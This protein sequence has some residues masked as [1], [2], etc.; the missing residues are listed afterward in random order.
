MND[1]SGYDNRN[2]NERYYDNREDMYYRDDEYRDYRNYRD[3]YR[4]RDYDRRGGRINNRDYR[5][6]RNSRNY[7][8]DYYEDLEM[9]IEDMKETSRMLEDIAEMASNMNEKN[10]INK[11]AQKEKEHST[12]LKQMLDKNI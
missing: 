2:R 3:D 5:N 1:M 8:E 4:R 11:V 10:M 6:Y 12:M 9:T 7:R